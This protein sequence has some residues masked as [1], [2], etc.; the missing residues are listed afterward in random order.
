M[1]KAKK[2][3]KKNPK[4]LPAKRTLLLLPLL[5]YVVASKSGLVG[6]GALPS[7]MG[8]VQTLRTTPRPILNAF[9]KAK[10]LRRFRRQ[11]A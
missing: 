10:L 2:K 11:V 7:K 8:W 5:L 9:R 4:T 1:F 3:K 6:A